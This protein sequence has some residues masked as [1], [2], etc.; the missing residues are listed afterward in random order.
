MLA[1]SAFRPTGPLLAWARWVR[2]STAVGSRRGPPPRPLSVDEMA[3]LLE[4]W[5]P[6]PRLAVAVS[7]GPD[8]MALAFL[9]AQWAQRTGRSV[10]AVTV[11]HALRPESGA[12][13]ATVS[14]RLA[15][16][17]LPSVVE[18]VDWSSASNHAVL[19]LE[20]ML[21]SEE[22][23]EAEPEDLEDGAAGSGT[24]R[25]AH[26]QEQAR[27]RRHAIL[28]RVC[29]RHDVSY[30]TLASS[31]SGRRVAGLPGDPNVVLVVLVTS[32]PRSD[33]LLGHHLD[34]Q[35]ETVLSR[36]ARSSGI[37][38]LG[39]IHPVV[40]L[41]TTLRLLHPLL[42]VPKVRRDE[43]SV[44]LSPSVFFVTS[45]GR[46]GPVP[47]DAGPAHRHVRASRDRV[48]AGPVQ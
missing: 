37:D 4:P 29:Q 22:D 42:P 25:I 39:G 45:R 10:V 5:R 12:E 35:C 19:G 34:D 6:G 2:T 3:S 23:G 15:G 7:G 44:A 33:V 48:R 47:F 38:G 11:D 16:L 28:Q 14:Q 8:S 21:G 36:L 24:P 43:R 31:T 30:V 46:R 26:L 9:T 40:Q 1:R 32:F 27:T 17:G 18:R 20:R 13:A 41:S